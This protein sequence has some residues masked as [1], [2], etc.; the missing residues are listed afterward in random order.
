M[1]TVEQPWLHAAFQSG[2]VLCVL[3]DLFENWNYLSLVPYMISTEI[4]VS[5][6]LENL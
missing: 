1:A 3:C 5:L 6:N 4:F 2:A